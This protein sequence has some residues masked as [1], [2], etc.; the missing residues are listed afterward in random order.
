M[1]LQVYT[2]IGF[3]KGAQQS[4]SGKIGYLGFVDTILARQFSVVFNARYELAHLTS[5]AFALSQRQ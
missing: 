1:L 2:Q 3:N 5:R 4:F